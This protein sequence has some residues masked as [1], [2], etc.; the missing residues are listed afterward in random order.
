[1]QNHVYPGCK[2]GV[3]SGSTVKYLVEYLEHAYQAGSL[4]DL[5]CVPSSFMSK[6]W[7]IDS[8][9][10]VSDLD[11]IPVLDVC[12]DGADAVD[13]DGTCIKGGCGL[14]REKILLESARK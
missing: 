9:L 5:I 3:G 14:T 11:A 1:T 10:P 6:K 12:I 13:A 2:L 4:R 8:G 7:L